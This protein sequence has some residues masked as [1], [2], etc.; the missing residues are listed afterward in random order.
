MDG[1]IPVETMYFNNTRY[2]GHQAMHAVWDATV[3]DA[4][5]DAPSLAVMSRRVGPTYGLKSINYVA[6]TLGKYASALD[7]KA[8]VVW[9]S[10]RPWAEV[11]LARAGAAHLTTIDYGRITSTHP[12]FT[13]TTP[14]ALAAMMLTAPRAWDFA[15]TFSSL[16]HS[17]LGR[18]GDA[19][20]PWGD[21]EAAVQTWCLLKPGGLFFLGVPCKNVACSEDVLFWNAHRFY[22]PLRLGEMSAG[23]ELVETVRTEDVSPFASVIHVLRK[24]G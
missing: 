20:N 6:H 24:K 22:G 8:G 18:Y 3:L 9:G 21:M 12:R 1:R 14:P 17:G 7:G 19:L 23:Y 10:E 13:T 5:V 4:G 2:S 15:F 16:E 11:L